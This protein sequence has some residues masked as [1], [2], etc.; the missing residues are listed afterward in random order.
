M[1]AIL[2]ELREGLVPMVREA[3]DS[4]PA[5]EDLFRGDFPEAAQRRLVQTLVA[6]LPFPDT[7]WRLDPT[8]H[9]FATSVGQRDVRLTTRFDASNLEMSIFSSLHESGHGLYEAGVDDALARTPLA[10]PRSLGMH[11][12]QSRLWENWVGRSTPYLSH[13]L[14][15]LRQSFPDRFDGVDI[16]RLERAANLVRRS[17][18]RID[19][20]EVT[21]NV[22]ILIRFELELE[23]FEEGLEAA[24]LPEAW[25][26]RYRSYLGIEVPDDAQGVLQDIHWAGG[27][28]GYFPTYSLGNVIA[29]QLWLAAQRDIADLDGRIA[30][31]DFTPLGEWLVD[32][33]HR[34][35]RR[36]SIAEILE[37]AGCGPLSVE[38]L[39]EHLRTRLAIGA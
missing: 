8:D 3:P 12:S 16:D 9:P 28:F 29:A 18:I 30:E 13:L 37:S 23:L 25:N 31:G 33:V 21:Y 1:Q 5:G 36:R 6:E 14:P 39:V 34:H 38:P 32:R 17:L 35:G 24:D 10:K 15:Q 19:S 2:G 27:A 4:A 22:H 20:D 11:E 7:S 26:E